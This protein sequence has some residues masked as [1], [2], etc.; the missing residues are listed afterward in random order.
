MIVQM[1][2]SAAFQVFTDN[3]IAAGGGG[4]HVRLI[5]KNNPWSL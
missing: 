4:V 1:H 3:I 5:L 2:H